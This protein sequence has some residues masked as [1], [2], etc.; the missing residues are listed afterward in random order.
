VKSSRL[1]KSAAFTIAISDAPLELKEQDVPTAKCRT[2]PTAQRVY[3]C[4]P[5][6][7]PFASL[8]A[9]SH[10]RRPGLRFA[11]PTALFRHRWH[12]R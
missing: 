4:S 12:F 9:H 1:P 6:R 7:W 11:A 8:D 5:T 3:A 10:S 2:A